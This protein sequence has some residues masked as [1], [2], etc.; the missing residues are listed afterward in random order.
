MKEISL[1]L[2]CSDDGDD[3]ACESLEEISQI[4]SFMVMMML[5]KV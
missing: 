1:I 4:R 5:V 2:S 3:D